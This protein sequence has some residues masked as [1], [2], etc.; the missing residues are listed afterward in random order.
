MDN[1]NKT[2]DKKL[3]IKDE[4]EV[5]AYDYDTL[6]DEVEKMEDNSRWITGIPSKDLVIKPI[7]DAFSVP[8]IL[9]ETEMDED[10]VMDTVNA[11][12]LYAALPDG[13]TKCIRNTGRTTLFDRAG[14]LGPALGREC[15]EDLSKTLNMALKVATGQS[16]ILLRYGKI[17]AFHSDAGAGYRFIPISQL[18]RITKNELEEKFGTPIFH[19]GTNSHSYTKAVWIMPDAKEKIS[20][21]YEKVLKESAVASRWD[22]TD[23]IP[24]ARL[25]TSDTATSAATLQPLFMTQRGTFIRLVDGIKVKHQRATDEKKKDGLELFEELVKQEFFARFQEGVE[26]V[27]ALSQIEIWHPENVVVGLCNK[28]RIPKKYGDGAREQVERFMVSASC[29]TAYDVYMSLS[30]A[31]SSGLE[32]GLNETAY[33]GMEEKLF[34]LLNPSFDWKAL[35]V[36]GIVAWG[37]TTP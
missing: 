5:V 2:E 32:I 19:D 33:L 10:C 11:T 9:A 22:V 7:P 29:L 13:T 21:H 30:E 8:D 24:A 1:T 20:T 23:L 27:D 28:F 12:G 35:D 3:Y 37:S 25:T 6:V 14:L 31:L 18:L 4:Y 36:S 15:V 17:S 16:L 34:S 26:S